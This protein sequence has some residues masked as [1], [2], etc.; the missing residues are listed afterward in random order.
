MPRLFLKG[1][2]SDEMVV[3]LG[4]LLGAK[5][6][7]FSVSTVYRLTRQWQTEMVWWRQCVLSDE[8]FAYICSDGIW[9]SVCSAD[10]K[11]CTL[12][13]IVVNEHGKKKILAIGDDALRLRATL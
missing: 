1:V 3:A 2:S 6:S 12:V 4:V 13:V 10:I 7:C 8:R 9:C 11:L 5:A